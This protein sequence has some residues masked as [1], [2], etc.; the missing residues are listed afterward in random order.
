V[1]RADTLVEV[2]MDDLESKLTEMNE[3]IEEI[4]VRL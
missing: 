1:A 3:R 2:E 4:Q